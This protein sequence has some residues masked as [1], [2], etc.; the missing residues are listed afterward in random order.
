MADPKELLLL[1]LARLTCANFA[2][3]H[4]ESLHPYFVKLKTVLAEPSKEP[5]YQ[6][7]FNEIKKAIE[8]LE[9]TPSQMVPSTRE[10]AE[11]IGL[12]R[13]TVVRC[14]ADLLARGYIYTVDGVGTFVRAAEKS[15]SK[16]KSQRWPI[17]AKTKKLLATSRA[18]LFSHDFPELNFGC[19]PP[20]LLPLKTWRQIQLKHARQTSSQELDYGADP[21]GYRPLRE[22]LA[23]LLTRVRAVSCSAD[24]IIVFPSSL[25]PLHLV[26]ETIVNAEQK[27]ILADPEQP[28]SRQTFE[29]VGANVLFVPVDEEGIKLDQLKPEHC[30]GSVVY[31][32]A[33][34]HNPSGAILSNSRRKQLLGL[35][36]SNRMFIIED[37]SN[38]ENRQGASPLPS[39]Q[40][41]SDSNNVIYLSNFWSTLYPLINL[42]FLVIPSD[43]IPLFEQIWRVTYHTFQTQLPMLEQLTMR[44]F[45]A[46]GHFERQIRKTEKVYF[47]WW[48]QLVQDLRS[49]FGQNVQIMKSSGGNA[50]LMRLPKEWDHEQILKAARE[51]NFALVSTADFYSQNPPENEFLAPFIQLENE[52]NST[53]RIK[54][55][56]RSLRSS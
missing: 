18:G 26:A 33:S 13:S 6:R 36:S 28:Y 7:L 49:E 55:F 53:Q 31:V 45:L 22:A 16:E 38:W 19:T 47:S 48:R 39:L 43:L 27:V 5:I 17:S 14:Y 44:E 23:E 32:T 29:E 52:V 24:Q 4:E 51:S 50:L 54:E 8:N 41:M 35:A 25:Y 37:D 10:L 30:Q 9:L 15:P 46:E 3:M 56:S 40:G 1:L 20:E 12:S 42:G 34:H 21:F 2:S 11:T